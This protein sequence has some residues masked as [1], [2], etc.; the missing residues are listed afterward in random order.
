MKLYSKDVNNM[1]MISAW[2]FT[3][4]ISS[5]LFLYIGRLIDVQYNTEPTFMVGLL[6]LAIILTI[7]RFYSKIVKNHII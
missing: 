6:I 1:I 4:V 7:F 5:F 3:I 2:G